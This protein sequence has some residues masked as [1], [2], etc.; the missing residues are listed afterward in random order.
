MPDIANLVAQQKLSN[1]GGAGPDAARSW[2][3]AYTWNAGATTFVSIFLNITDTASAAGSLI[4]DWQVGGASKFKVSKAGNGTFA[5]TVTATNIPATVGDVVGPASSADNGLPRFDGTTGK[6]IQA[7]GLATLDD[8]GTLKITPTTAAGAVPVLWAA[9]S[10]AAFVKLFDNGTAVVDADVG[11]GTNP[12]II[13]YAGSNRFTF[14]Y[15]GVFN[16]TTSGSII[17]P[18]VNAECQLGSSGVG[19]KLLYLDYTNTATVGA[20]TINKASGRV[21]I[22][23]AGTSVVVTNSLVTAAS[24]V[25]AVVSTNDSTARVTAVVPAA[26]SFTIYTVAT[27]AETTFDFV[28]IS[29]D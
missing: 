19:F 11:T 21:R 12:L 16:T 18:S 4:N 28:V 29:A 13:K 23:A 17:G 22:A 1:L 20:V 26:G 24:H 10:G 2:D 27:T 9:S 8:A 5:G 7:G 15:Q 6:L 3:F 25:L 14:N